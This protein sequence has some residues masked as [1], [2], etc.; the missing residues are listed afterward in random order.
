[1]KNVTRRELLR[2]GCCSLSRLALGGSLARLGLMN[3][4]A[5]TAPDYKALVC[6]FLFGGNDANNMVVPL[7][8]AA[9]AAYQGVR[10]TVALPQATLLPAPA[11][12]G[13][14]Y[15][16]H[17]RFVDIHPLW[18]QRRLA[19][20]LNVG[21]L[22]RPLTRDEYRRNAAPVPGNL[23]S[24]SDQQQ[25]W[26]NASPLTNPGTG[27]AGRASDLLTAQGVNGASAFPL[28]VSVAG[29]SL[30]LN[31]QTTKPATVIPGT[32][33][34]LQG[35]NPDNPAMVARDKALADL[36]TFDTGFSLVQSLSNSTREG[37]R[38]ASILNGT[39][40]TTPLTTQFPQTGLGQQLAQVARVIQ[41]RNALGMRRQIFFVSAGG[42]DTHTNQLP[43]QDNLFLQLS[44]AMA[45]FY[46]ATGEM[47]VATNVTTFLESEFGRTFQPSGGVAA[48]T[49]HAWGSH[50]LVMG[51]AVRGDV[52]GTM[53]TLALGGP[54]D[55]G[56]RGAW[57]PTLSLDQYGAT[58]AA[59]FG[60][61]PENMAAVFPNLGNFA[62]KNI[63]FVA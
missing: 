42:Y 3:A 19:A 30:L 62:V 43:D 55:A 23:Y 16:L 60:V 38:I 33:G 20:V 1:M 26:Q 52:Y 22:V 21:M 46:N 44:Q 53:P 32:N 45:A 37:L 11:V 24:H 9:Y 59:W 31:G 13:T 54:D 51:G 28:G 4:Y 8:P 47:G 18:A 58:L 17:P 61:R 34:G 6:V 56:S 27:W 10:Q 50:M 5:Q 57:I 25:Q 12:N 14:L 35:S 7:A 41:M 49:D 36:L 39:A 29:G 63:G 40:Q 15:G 48:G 2:V